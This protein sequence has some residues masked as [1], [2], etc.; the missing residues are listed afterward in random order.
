[1]LA[2][3]LI[4]V[5]ITLILNSIMM[6][7]GKDEK[8]LVI[9]NLFTSILI[10]IFNF[11]QILTVE[12]TL[13]FVGFMGGLLFGFTNLIVAFDIIL[14]Q[15]Y[16]LTGIFS[17]VAFLSA[18]AISVFNFLSGDILKGVSW[19]VW[20]TLWLFNFFALIVSKKMEKANYIMQLTQGILTT[21]VF[22]FLQLFQIIKF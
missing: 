8:T 6:L 18:V 2:I 9:V 3:I 13:E 5:G 16:F 21:F 11:Y 14:K 17:G 1:M 15:G 20:S 10:F 12:N 19:L 4:F 22:G 7:S